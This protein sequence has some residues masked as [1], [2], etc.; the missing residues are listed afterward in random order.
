VKWSIAFPGQALGRAGRLD[1]RGRQRQGCEYE[2]SGRLLRQI[3]L[4]HGR[5][6]ADKEGLK[7]AEEQIESQR[8]SM[9]SEEGD[10]AVK[11]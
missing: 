6:P 2:A 7:R 11:P 9:S 3:E 5:H 1:L 8:A 10:A 4:P